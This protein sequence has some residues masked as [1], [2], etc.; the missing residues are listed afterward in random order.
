VTSRPY[1]L[2]DV[3]ARQSRHQEVRDHD[4]VD[5]RVELRQA[6]I[7]VN[8]RVR[9]IPQ[10]LEK[11]DEELPDER[12]V[13]DDERFH[14]VFANPAPENVSPRRGVAWP[15]EYSRSSRGTIRPS[16]GKYD[17][18]G[19]SRVATIPLMC[20]VSFPG[21]RSSH[22]SVSPGMRAIE[23][24]PLVLNVLAVLAGTTGDEPRNA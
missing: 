3:E 19:P 24:P 5:E 14:F 15:V 23:V 4:L 8:R 9:L 13:I 21:L 18:R 20:M 12:F 17:T 10:D 22:P 2:R 6:L 7:P 1:R 16:S 11:L